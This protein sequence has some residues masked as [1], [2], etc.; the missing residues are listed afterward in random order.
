MTNDRV[1]KQVLF[2]ELFE[3]KRPRGRIKL[4]YKDVCKN[5][6]CDF[7]ID[8]KTWESLAVDSFTWRDTLRRGIAASEITQKAKME[9]QRRRRKAR[10]Q[11]W[12]PV[13][14]SQL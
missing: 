5:S 2:G 13:P 6:L 10:D 4:R 9:E 1:L 14:V 3:G 12:D 11:H 8:N 7:N